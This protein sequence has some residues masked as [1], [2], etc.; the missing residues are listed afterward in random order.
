[1]V[2]RWKPRLTPPGSFAAAHGRSPSIAA[3]ALAPVPLGAARAW[4]RL[5]LGLG[6][7]RVA[8]QSTATD[9]VG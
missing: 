4:S 5:I 7:P 2:T 1:M 3:A 8:L 6:G 9:C